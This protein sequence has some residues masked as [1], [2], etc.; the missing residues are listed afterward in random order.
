M[1]HLQ[2]LWLSKSLEAM[3]RRMLSQAMSWLSRSLVGHDGPL[4]ATAVQ[5]LQ[6]LSLSL[7]RHDAPVIA[8]AVQVLQA[9]SLT[10]VRHDAPVV[11]RRWV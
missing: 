3:K 8:T 5:V 11:S 2:I 9:L 10:L 1:A 7:I 6:A 4:I